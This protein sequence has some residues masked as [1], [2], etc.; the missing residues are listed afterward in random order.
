MNT[1][2]EELPKTESDVHF[3]VDVRDR[4]ILI[5]DDELVNI[6]VVRKYLQNTG[7]SRFVTTTDAHEA[8]PMMLHEAPDLVLLDVMMP[9]IDGLQILQ[10]MRHDERLRYIPAL[11]LTAVSDPKTKT[12]ALQLG[13]TDFLAKPVDPADLQPRVRNA[14]ISKAHHDE[15][16]S[17]AERL[18]QEVRMRTAELEASRQDMIFC[19]AGAGEYRDQETGNHV[20]RVGLFAGIVARELGMDSEVADL[21]EQA[22]LLHDVGKIGVSDLIL[23]KPGKLSDAEYALMKKHCEF[24]RNI[25]Q[26]ST[27]IR[28]RKVGNRMVHGQD[29][30]PVGQ[31]PIMAMAARIAISH[32]ERWDGTGYP[33][34]LRGEEIPIEG[35]IVSVV[36]VF[37]ALSSV[38]PYKPAINLKKCFEIMDEGRGSHFDPA[39]YDAFIRAKDAILKVQREYADPVTESPEESLRRAFSSHRAR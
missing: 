39:V 33:D 22:A 37:D 1:A 14:L 18:E 36:D 10:Q 4:K 12:R 38:R 29:R 27:D 34:G 15:L 11:I 13:A 16:E 6:K 32:H 28:W 21:L 7:Y 3:A 35:R 30:I 20:V 5:V 23:L 19:L 25:I 2:T 26:P 24:G 31:S 9:G 8:I 17:Y